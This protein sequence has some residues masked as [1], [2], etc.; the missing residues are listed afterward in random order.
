MRASPQLG[1]ALRI[2]IGSPVE[3]DA[4]LAALAAGRVAA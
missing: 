1:D 2:S 4:M 3:N